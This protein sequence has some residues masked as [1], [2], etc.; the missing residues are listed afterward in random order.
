[1]A[2]DNKVEDNPEPAASHTTPQESLSKNRHKIIIERV[3][4]TS[5]EWLAHVIVVLL[6]L[7]GI[8]LVERV[9]HLF[10]SEGYIFFAETR[11]ALPMKYI[12]DSADAALLFGFCTYGI[13]AVVKAYTSS[14]KKSSKDNKV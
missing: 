9:C 8:W 4:E 14:G 5:T 12:F 13:I 7:F 6:L 11:C 2:A 10:W 1:M 3:V